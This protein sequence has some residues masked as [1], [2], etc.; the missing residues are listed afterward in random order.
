LSAIL[1]IEFLSFI[2]LVLTD[3]ASAFLPVCTCLSV[4]NIAL[5]VSS[6][7]HET[8]NDYA[9]LLSEERVKFWG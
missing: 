5:K 7:F 1:N 9:L 2:L 4:S 6:D 8:L 3:F